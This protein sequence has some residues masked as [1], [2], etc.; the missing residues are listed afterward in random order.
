MNQPGVVPEWRSVS[1]GGEAVTLD[2]LLRLTSGLDL[3]EDQSGAEPNA[4]M[5]FVEPDAAAYVVSR[6]LEAAPG[7]HW[8]YMSGSTVLASRAVVDATGGTLESSQRFI[9]EAL[10]MP[11]GAPTHAATHRAEIVAV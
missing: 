2:H 7:T 4:R 9:R 1:D 3:A 5:L 8:K 10:L 11:V 6:R